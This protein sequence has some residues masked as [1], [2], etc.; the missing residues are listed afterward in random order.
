VALFGLTASPDGTMLAFAPNTMPEGGQPQ[1]RVLMIMPTSGGRP[2]EVLRSSRLTIA[3]AMS[4]TKDSRHLILTARAPG[5]ADDE[6]QHQVYALPVE[7]GE[8]KP[9]GLS[10]ERIAS[11]MVSADGQHIAFTAET[12]KQELWVIRNLLSEPAAR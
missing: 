1:Q 9:L 5:A 10:M 4:W 3:N 7:G 2:R 8:L 11:R 6:G 12:R